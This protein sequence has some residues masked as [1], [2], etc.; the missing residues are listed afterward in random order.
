M[1]KDKLFLFQPKD[2]NTGATVGGFNFNDAIQA[3][4]LFKYDDYMENIV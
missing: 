4:V 1:N 3:M 2:L